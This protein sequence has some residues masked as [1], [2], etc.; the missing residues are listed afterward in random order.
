M[1]IDFSLL[2]LSKLKSQT[3]DTLTK[4]ALFSLCMK[5]KKHEIIQK[6]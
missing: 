6:R 5:E 3:L 1:L 2:V 4:K